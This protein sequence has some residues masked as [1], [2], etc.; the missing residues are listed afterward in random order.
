MLIQS[1][2]L[3]VN[4]ISMRKKILIGVVLYIVEHM[5][6]ICGGVVVKGT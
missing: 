6:T 5:V 2:V 1:F 3:I 4:K